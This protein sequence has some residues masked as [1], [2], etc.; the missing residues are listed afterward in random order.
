MTTAFRSTARCIGWFTDDTPKRFEAYGWHVVR[1]VDGHDPDAIARAIAAARR[2][3][4]RPT[5]ICCKTII[6]CGSPNKQ[7]TGGIP[8]RGARRGGSRRRPQG[9]GLAARAVRD[10]GGDSRRLGCAR[11]RQAR[12]EPNGAGASTPTRRRIPSSPP[13]S[14]GA[15]TLPCRWTSTPGSRRVPPRRRRRRSRS[16]RARA[17]RPCSTAS[18]RSCRSCSAA[19]PTSPVRTTR[20][21]RAPRHSRLRHPAGNYLHYGVREFGMAAIMNGIALHGGFIPFGGTFLVFSDYARNAL[22]MAALMKRRTIFVLTHDSIG[23]GEDGPTHQPVEHVATL[24]MIPNMEVWRPCDTVGDGGR[25]G[26]GNR[27]AGTAPTVLAAHAAGTAAAAARAGAD[28]RHRARRLCARRRRRPSRLHPDRDR[29]GSRGSRSRPRAQL[30]GRGPQGAGRVDALHQ[31]LRRAGR[32]LAR[33]V[34]PPAVG[35]RVAIEAGV[36]DGWW[37]YV[38]PRGPVVGMNG[39]GASAPAK[40]LFRHF[41]F[42]VRHRRG[43]GGVIVKRRVAHHG[44]QGWHQRLRPHRTQH[45]ARAVRGEAFGRDQHRRRST[46][47]ATRRPTRT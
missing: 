10:S 45:P 27:A 32:G 47:S 17:R 7:G 29:L 28:R 11:V 16:R 46:I 6:G 3:K 36:T 1:A 13:N 22:R 30:A 31:R 35:A 15:R 42:T 4:A 24:R 43:G 14:A 44:H 2:E 8:R 40:D 41:G 9:A 39:F 21:S 18:A 19:R 5:L 38:G 37:R 23:L 25:V 12:R 20:A 26:R 34:L 33:A